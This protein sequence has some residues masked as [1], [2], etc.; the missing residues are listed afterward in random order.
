MTNS[1]LHTDPLSNLDGVEEVSVALRSLE[2]WKAFA[3]ANP[4]VY[5]ADLARETAWTRLQANGF[6]EPITHRVVPGSEI[7]FGDSLRE[8]LENN[9]ISSRVR[10][11]LH[12]IE[13]FGV[14]HSTRIYG[15][16]AMTAFAMMMRGRFPRYYG[17]EYGSTEAV[18]QQMFPIPH[19]DLTQ[20]SFKD[21][22]FDVVTT[23][24]VLEHVPDLDAA[25]REMARVLRPGGRHIGTMPFALVQEVGIVK[26]RIVDG[27][28]VHLME[29][30]YHGNPFEE[31]GAL[32]FEVPGWN[33]L[34]RARA[35]GFSD[36]WIQFAWSVRH[37][38]FT[39]NTGVAL[40]VLEK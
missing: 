19:E 6:I 18:R 21:E 15:A 16:E 12:E 25:L 26:A 11:V 40:L 38:Y 1:V 3:A 29:P 4:F 10:A 14:D 22:A 24:E 27:E 23:N 28:L 32:V 7:N 33:V 17:S 30:E 5:S 35:A 36:A 20:L 39:E 2:E 13:R 8:G 31:G 9:H 34:E 37:G